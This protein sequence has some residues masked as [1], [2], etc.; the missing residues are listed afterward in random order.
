[1]RDLN[2]ATPPT[3]AVCGRQRRYDELDRWTCRPCQHRLD[4]RLAWI[5]WAYG[6]L[7]HHLVPGSRGS[8]GR[9]S[10]SRS[11]PMPFTAEAADLRGP[12]DEA[13]VGKLLVHEDSWRATLRYPKVT[14]RGS[15]EQTLAATV[16]FLRGNLL[17]AC[18]SYPDLDDLDRDLAKLY[19]RARPIVTGEKPETKVTV[20]CGCG[21]TLRITLSTPGRRCGCG[22]S[23]SWEELRDLPLADRAAA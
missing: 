14:F 17:W 5:E 12:G 3:C 7:A 11:A 1:M 2:D 23:Y 15:L 9:V 4:E 16:A 18:T 22:V 19:G 21:G 6:E 13:I 8:G 10:G 20:R